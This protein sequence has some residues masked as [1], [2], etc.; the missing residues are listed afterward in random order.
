MKHRLIPFVVL[1]FLSL[2]V[3]L[4]TGNNLYYIFFSVFIIIAILAALLTPTPDVVD[5]Y[6]TDDQPAVY[7]RL[8]DQLLAT[9]EY[10]E[11][12]ARPWLDL[13]RY[14][15]TVGYHGDQDHNISPYRD[16]VIRS[17]NENLSFDQFPVP[18]Y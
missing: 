11:R 13:A 18:V 10:A 16:Y 17:L 12:F 6:L 5:R 2:L 4:M 3:G 8:V 9:P 14:A 1:T 7:R 15:D